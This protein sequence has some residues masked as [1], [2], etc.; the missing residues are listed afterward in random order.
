MRS[1]IVRI[2]IALAARAGAPSFAQSEDRVP[3]TSIK[4]LLKDAIEH[5]SARGVLAGD[6][7]AYVRQRFDATAPIEIDVR[8]LHALPKSGCSR[9]EVTTRQRAVLENGKREDKQL[10]YQISYC[11]DGTFPEKR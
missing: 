2:A 3:V 7:G 4:P 6:A 9:L 1:T 10:V 11:R 8:S 5:G